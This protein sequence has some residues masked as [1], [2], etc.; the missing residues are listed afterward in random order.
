MSKGENGGRFG[1]IH[2][3]I[4]D[5]YCLFNGAYIEQET[6]KNSQINEQDNC[7]EENKVGWCGRKRLGLEL[8]GG[9]IEIRLP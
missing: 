6:G 8:L 7:Y 3:L 2:V 1:H 5:K 9:E 4:C